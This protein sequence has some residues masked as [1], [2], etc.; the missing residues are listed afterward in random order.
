[1]I[2][3]LY[4]IY[5]CTTVF[6]FDGSSKPNTYADKTVKH[7]KQ[8]QNRR[9]QQVYVYREHVNR[10]KL[11]RKSDFWRYGHANNGYSHCHGIRVFVCSHEWNGCQKKNGKIFKCIPTYDVKE[12]F[13]LFCYVKM[14]QKRET[15]VLCVCMCACVW[16]R[17]VGLLHTAHSPQKYRIRLD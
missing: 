3:L 15:V 12:F 9:F 4:G 8:K 1:M 2:F 17:C 11:A 13:N 6:P 7:S 16:C 10:W 14:A 5:F